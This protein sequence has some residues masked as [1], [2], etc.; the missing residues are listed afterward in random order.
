M[1]IRI[2]GCT[3][4]ICESCLKRAQGKCP[5][6]CCYDSWRAAHDSQHRCLGGIHYEIDACDEYVEYK[7][8][9]IKYCLNA[10]ITIYQDGSICCPLVECLGCEE[11][12]EL[13][14]SKQSEE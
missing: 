1:R 3:G 9:E 5:Y 14:E 13:F 2:G 8:A 4:C 10:A 6:G 7:G 12:Y 11:C